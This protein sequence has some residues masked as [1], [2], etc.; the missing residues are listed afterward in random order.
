MASLFADGWDEALSMSLTV[1][2]PM[3]RKPPSTTSSFSMRRACRSWR[4]S[5]GAMPGR[6][7]TRPSAVIKPLTGTAGSLANRTSR[8][9]R[10]PTRT[11][12]PL[13]TTG[14]PLILW[15]SIRALASAS[16][17]SG[18]MVTGST[19]IPLSNFLTRRTWSAC[20]ATVRFL[21]MTPSP[22]R[23]AMAMAIADS[24]TVSIAAETRGT[25]RGISL[26]NRERVSAPDGS[27]EE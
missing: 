18:W 6:T 11:P 4:A 26:A 7:V 15:R 14:M 5:S 12:L 10:I 27:T 17:W 24:L 8:L 21:W 9:V 20:S 22:P 2:R 25:W 3:Q 19:T 13:A 23:R 1:T 16:V